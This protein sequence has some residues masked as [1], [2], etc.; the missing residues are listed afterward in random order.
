MTTI[1]NTANTAITNSTSVFVPTNFLGPLKDDSSCYNIE[2]I[3]LLNIMY[4][5]F[6][7]Y[8]V[9][10]YFP[11]LLFHIKNKAGMED[12]GILSVIENVVDYVKNIMNRNY[13]HLLTISKSFVL[14]MSTL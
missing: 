4:L 8:R 14:T 10:W 5:L 6:Y 1:T 2:L 13:I 12:V 9:Q 7:L 3:I 11:L